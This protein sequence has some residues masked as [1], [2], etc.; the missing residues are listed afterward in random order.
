M[1][2]TNANI[3]LYKAILEQEGIQFALFDQDLTLKAASRVIR[4]SANAAGSHLA[5]VFPELAGME[6]AILSS[7]QQGDEIFIPR[8]NRPQNGEGHYFDLRLAPLDGQ[9]LVILKDSTIS[10]SLEQKLAQQRNEMILL[11][12]ELEKSYRMLRNLSGLDELTQLSN[13]NA[14]QRIFQHRLAQA[15]KHHLP[16]SL[17]FLDLD[18]LKQIN[19]THGHESGDRALIHLAAAM[20]AH[21]RS[22][23]MAARW[24]GD[25]F[26]IMLVE[27]PQGARRIA[28]ALLDAL[29]ERPCVFPNGMQENLR[30]SIGICHVA[31][32]TI[33]EVPL[34]KILAAADRAMYLSKRSGGNRF[35]EINL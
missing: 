11:N 26:A 5:D 34:E 2:A 31:P 12:L 14:A 32:Q 23:D 18:N 22:A 17:I 13:R 8:L 30:V 25:E 15:Q 6:D 29:A 19:D 24:G 10:G 16:L 28:N 1:K 21:V 3:F 9:I 4:E 33:K 35:T 20:R 7:I 27:E